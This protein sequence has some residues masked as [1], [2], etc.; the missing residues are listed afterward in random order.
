MCKEIYCI[1][2]LECN[3]ILSSDN[4][5][6]GHYM[7]LCMTK[8]LLCFNLENVFIYFFTVK[9]TIVDPPIIC[10][11]TA[12]LSSVTVKPNTSSNAHSVTSGLGGKDYLILTFTGGTADRRKYAEIRKQHGRT[13]KSILQI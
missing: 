8:H 11:T 13:L 10:G 6:K 5:Y 3:N 2:K 4:P 1:L 7:E 9:W 12:A